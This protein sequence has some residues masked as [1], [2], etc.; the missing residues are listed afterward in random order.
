M[1]AISP[2]SWLSDVATEGVPG[3]ILEILRR[4]ARGGSLYRDMSDMDTDE[5]LRGLLRADRRERARGARVRRGRSGERHE[6][7]DAH[8][9]RRPG[10]LGPTGIRHLKKS[11]RLGSLK[12]YGPQ[13]ETSDSPSNWEFVTQEPELLC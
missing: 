11:F 2:L 4:R 9:A 6:E 7:I 13:T 10:H 12:L 8:D 1:L 5:A 3:Q